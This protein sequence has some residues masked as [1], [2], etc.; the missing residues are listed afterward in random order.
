VALTHLIRHPLALLVLAALAWPSHALALIE[1]PVTIDGPSPDVRDVGGVAIASDGTGGVAYVKIDQGVPHVFVSRRLHNGWTAPVRVDALPYDATAPSIAASDHGRLLVVWVSQI[2]TVHGQIRRALYSAEL[3]AGGAA[4][5]SPLLVDP[6]VADG[7]DGTDVAPSLA[8]TVAGRAIVAYRVTTFDFGPNSGTSDAVR[9]RPNDVMADVRVARYQGTRW[10]RLGA[11]NRNADASMPPAGP[12]NAPRVGVA[13][14][15]SA[16]VAWQERDQQA[17]ARIWARRVFGT[18]LGPILAASPATWQGQP[19]TDGADALAL[20]VSP[21]G[22]A[23]VVA[24]VPGADATTRVFANRLPVSLDDHAGQFSGAV[25]AD[26]GPLAG[27][28][29]RPAVAVADSGQDGSSRVGFSA[30]GALRATALGDAS[31]LGDPPLTPAPA[32]GGDVGLAQAASGATV[33]AWA[34]TGAD[35]LPAV[36]VRQA[37]PSGAVQ[38]GVLAGAEAGDVSGLDLASDVGGDALVAFLQGS[39]RAHEIVAE[40]ITSAPARFTVTAPSGWVRPRSARLRWEAA[41]STTPRITYTVLLDGDPVA[42]GIA[43]RALVPA[44][45][46]LGNGVRE[47][48]VI[49]TDAQ[50]QAIASDPV[51]LKVDARPPTAKVALAPRRRYGRR[52]VVVTVADPASG[53]V[54]ARTTCLFGDGTKRAKG[55]R[56]FRHRYQRP[57]RY[58]VRVVTR[59]RAGNATTLGLRVQVR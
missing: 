48:Q 54:A 7:G 33:A 41:P 47:V 20:A 52:A 37:H 31:P 29:G 12:G 53:V 2:A 14:D 59:D 13:D 50:G 57:G 34:T 44:A 5:G 10:S 55:H 1:P 49:G 11:I 22:M 28:V 6:N 32:Q 15:G 40:G 9:L 21:L 51:Q 4:F 25:A 45:D 42:R 27:T 43:A 17:T 18:S 16:V 8:G 26:G 56:T 58:V 19:V 39:S 23:Q 38:T 30:G 35:G 24:R 36:A 3:P 46:V